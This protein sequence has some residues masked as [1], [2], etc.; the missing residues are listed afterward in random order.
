MSTTGH[1]N[2]AINVQGLKAS[3]QKFKDEYTTDVAYLEEGESSAVIADFDPQTDTVWK[4]AQTLSNAEKSQVKTNLGLPQEIYSKTE[5]NNLITT[6]NQQYVTVATYASLPGTGSA[7]TIYRVSNYNGSTSHVDA[8]MY[9]E[10]AWNG[11][12]YEFLCV[13]SQIG[14]VFDITAYNS[15]TKYADLAAALGTNGANVPEGVRKGGMSVKYVSNSDNKYVQWRLMA[16]AFTTDI[17]QWQGVDDEPTA[18]SD[19]LVKSGGVYDTSIKLTELNVE[20]VQSNYRVSNEV[21]RFLVADNS[22][23]VILFNIGLNKK[24]KLVGT[25][26]EISVVRLCSSTSWGKPWVIVK[27]NI[28]QGDYVVYGET[29]SSCDYVAMTVDKNSDYHGYIYE[30]IQDWLQDIEDKLEKATNIEKELTKVKQTNNFITTNETTRF[31]TSNQG[32]DVILFEIGANKKF[33]IQGVCDTAFCVKLCSSLSYGAPY[34]N[35]KN[36]VSGSY[37]VIGE[38]TSDSTFVGITVNQ[39]STYHCFLIEEIKDAVHELQRVVDNNVLPN[40][41]KKV[42]IYTTDT[43]IEILSKMLSA[44]TEGNCDVI[45]E[46]GIYTFSS[47]YL[48][49]RDTLGWDWTMELPIGNNCHYYFNGSTLISNQP[50]EQFEDSRNILGCKAGESG[51]SSY[52]LYDGILINNGGTYCVHDE[53]SRD[54]K[55]Y[56]HKYENMRM[57]LNTGTATGNISKC[58]GGGCGQN[59]VVIIKNCTFKNSNEQVDV[60]WHGLMTQVSENPIKMWFQVENCYFLK[61]MVISSHF[62]TTD[63]LFV[64]YN[65]NSSPTDISIDGTPAT[66]DVIKFNNEI[67]N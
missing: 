32:T 61:G 46:N 26:S 48:Y 52:E 39:G 60:S 11:T 38:T 25:C 43:E 12:D 19:N 2:E 45:F 16:N 27:N 50:A 6:P 15:N 33:R 63:N 22:T 14:E 29:T 65:G 20:K 62:K 18:G 41:R 64:K 42:N 17:T 36:G 49:M 57:F 10:Y 53:C 31:G 4:K 21:E 47:V 55:P 58:I 8:T 59:G 54:S 7:D 24:F 3:L 30:D 37:D 56:I 51:K 44:Y 35:V 28:P 1:E 40:I 66:Q 5:V 9:S 67:R 13:K 23:D 34:V